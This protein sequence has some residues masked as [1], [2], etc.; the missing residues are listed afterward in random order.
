MQRIHVSADT[1]ALADEVARQF[2]EFARTAIAGHGRFCVALSGGNSP[3][4]T[5]RLLAQGA[6]GPLNRDVVHVFR[7]DERRV[8][9]G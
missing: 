1:D 3:L 8:P 4:P 7:S 6:A 5:L 9:R 2:G